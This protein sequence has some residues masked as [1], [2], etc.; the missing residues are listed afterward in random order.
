MDEWSGLILQYS[1]TIDSELELRFNEVI[2][3]YHRFLAKKDRRPPKLTL[4]TMIYAL[5][6]KDMDS[7][8][9]VAINN[10]SLSKLANNDKV[11]KQLNKLC[12]GY[13][14]KASHTENIT[15]EILVKF[16]RLYFEQ[17][18]L[19]NFLKCFT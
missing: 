17:S 15:D 4:G 8:F 14:N 9:S 12:Q 7:E 3:E 1:L 11:L 6:N 16:R 2:K 19:K 18:L 5:K 13:R 10:S